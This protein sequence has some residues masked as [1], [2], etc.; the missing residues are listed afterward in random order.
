MRFGSRQVLERLDLRLAPGERLGILGPSG[1]GKSTILRLAAGLLAPQQGRV[2]NAYERTA[3]VFQEPRLLP[4]RGV[5]ANLELPLRAAG[6]HAA[7][8][9][10]LAQDWLAR[11][12]LADHAAAWPGQLS[13]GMAQRVALAR[14]FALRPGLLLLDEPFSAL[15]PGLRQQL[16]M[17]CDHGL[18]QT[19][20]A[21]LYVSHHPQ[22]LLRLV[23]RCLV[24]EQGR[25]HLHDSGDA[26]GK[27]R[28]DSR[29][30]HAF[31]PTPT[32]TPTQTP[33]T[34]LFEPQS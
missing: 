19:G 9:R 2:V 30:R 32:P 29:L 27:A 31:A 16:G 3:M 5:R 25:W 26:D 14:A 22:E 7:E 17:L 11:V 21:L 24:Y 10:A 8:A 20:A 28:L 6:H 13:G 18:R 1:V 33:I 34:H 23:R 12:G 15:D 4:W